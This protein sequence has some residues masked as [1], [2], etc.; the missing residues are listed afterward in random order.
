[1]TGLAAKMDTD[2]PTPALV[3]L[4]VMS[5]SRLVRASKAADYGKEEKFCT[6]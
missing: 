5:R 6:R 4:F 3:A 2:V 1:M